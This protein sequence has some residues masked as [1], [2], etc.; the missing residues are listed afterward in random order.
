MSVPAGRVVVQLSGVCG[1]GWMDVM[2]WVEGRVDGCKRRAGGRHVIS[3][4]VEPYVTLFLHPLS[5]ELM[6]CTAKS[7]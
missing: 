3:L 1:M 4:S 6:S 7:D 5:K 2:G